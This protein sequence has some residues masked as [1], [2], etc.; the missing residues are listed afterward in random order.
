MSKLL[1]VP[2]IVATAANAYFAWLYFVLPRT[3]SMGAV[4]LW[5][6]VLAVLMLL[7]AYLATGLLLCAISKKLSA[8]RFLR[9]KST[10][11]A[12]LNVCACLLVVLAFW[13]RAQTEAAVSNGSALRANNPFNTAPLSVARTGRLRR[14]AG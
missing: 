8:V 9:R 5:F 1:W 13:N 2:G 3:P 4:V 10:V 6:M 12:A 7:S 14:P 11:I